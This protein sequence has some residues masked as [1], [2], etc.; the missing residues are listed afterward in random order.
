MAAGLTVDFLCRFSIPRHAFLRFGEPSER[1]PLDY[2]HQS[3]ITG[4]VRVPGSPMN[5]TPRYLSSP[6]TGV[7]RINAISLSAQSSTS[8]S[9]SELPLSFTMVLSP[10]ALAVI[11]E[12]IKLVEILVTLGADVNLGDGWG[13][14]PI[15]F[16]LAL[17]CH[18]F[19]PYHY[20][21]LIFFIIYYFPTP[22]FHHYMLSYVNF[23]HISKLPF[24]IHDQAIVVCN[25]L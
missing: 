17:V 22:S 16:A 11:I 14:S 19:N 21:K 15:M 18:I 13:R 4:S 8:S 3:L 23:Y 9:T 6:A 10:L 24:S 20:S 5:Q 12:N 1:E 2:F 25:T 7:R